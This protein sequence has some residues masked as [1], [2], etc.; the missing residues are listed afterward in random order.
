[1]F[2]EAA[3][4]L[5]SLGLALADYWDWRERHRLSI[6]FNF[7][8][9]VQNVESDALS[10]V[11]MSHREW[12]LCPDVFHRICRHFRIEAQLDL[13]ASSHNHQVP[14]YY[15][16]EHDS[17]AEGTNAFAHKWDHR[18]PMYAYPPRSSSLASF[19]NSATTES[20]M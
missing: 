6:S 9:G 1:M 17:A 13:F 4:P 8:A 2:I 10:R 11:K 18:G 7:L 16:F 3:T 12:Q 14:R 20:E 15:S 5:A 19:R